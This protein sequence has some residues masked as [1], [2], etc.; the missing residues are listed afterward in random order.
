[1]TRFTAIALLAVQFARTATAQRVVYTPVADDTLEARLALAAK[2]NQDRAAALEGLLREAGC[3]EP[4][5]ETRKVR[6]SKL[7]NIVCALPGQTGDIIVVGAH[8]DKVKAGMGAIDNWS[9]ASLLA[10]LYQSHRDSGLR[11][12]LVFVGFA[13]EEAGLVGS[14]DYVS[15][16]GKGDLARHK[17][18]VNLDSLAAGPLRVWLSRSSKPVVEIAANAAAALKVEIS[19]MNVDQVGDTDS[20]PFHDRRIPVIDF[21]SLDNDT[22]K[23][24]HSDKDQT[25]AVVRERYREAFRFLAVF[26]GAADIKLPELAAE[27]GRE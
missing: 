24:L 3:H 16:I 21:H 4:H 13:D 7:P 18:Y 19:A 22:V 9:G 2:R 20:H 23:L 26:L 15:R 17:L 5:L 8:Y 25:A 27:G 6:G 14:R 12:T 11:H 1:M 10:S